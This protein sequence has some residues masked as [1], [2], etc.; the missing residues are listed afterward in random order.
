[1]KLP[2]VF[3]AGSR[4]AQAVV[5]LAVK[6]IA[7]SDGGH[8]AAEQPCAYTTANQQPLRTAGE[9]ST[10]SENLVALFYAREA[11]HHDKPA[12]EW[13][14]QPVCT[15]G[16][17]PLLVGRY[18][19]ALRELGVARGDRVMLK[20]E[21]SPAYVFTYLAILAAGAIFVPLNAAYTAAEVG[22]LVDDADPILLVHASDTP[23]PPVDAAGGPAHM[24]LEPDGSGSLTDLANRLD[25]DLSVEPVTARDLAAILFTSGTTGRPKG[26]ML[27]HGNLSS[28]VAA[29]HQTWQFSDAD[30][31][32]HTLPL[33]HAHGLFVA[34]HLGLYSAATL[35]MLPR[36][37]AA[38]VV[39]LLGEVSVFMGVPTFYTRLL[40]HPG[41]TREAVAAI[42]L[43]VSGSAPLLPSVFEAFEART[44]HRILER[45]GM[46]EAV[47]IT[48]NPY[49]Q[50]GRIPGTVGFPLPGVSLRIVGGA[51][52]AELPCGEVGE[53]EISGPNLC[54]GYWRRPEANAEAFHADGYFITGDTGF[55][56]DTGRVTIAGRSKDLIIS[57]GFNVYPAELEILLAE[58][59]GVT[60]IAVIGVPH[61]DF[62]EAV[63]AVVTADAGFVPASIN[64]LA[65]ERLARFKQPKAVFVLPE[66]PRNAMG[67]VLKAELR[68]RFG[69]TFTV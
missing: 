30:S 53:I 44:G 33:F 59:P 19:A 47:M 61:P 1:V 23:V 28:N 20:T 21:N 13:Q 58:V 40:D 49:D 62:G 60:D 45:Y 36:F 57:G 68:R 41:M 4:G 2:P 55:R 64:E 6:A 12:I 43:F 32:L 69:G 31:I 26:A 24:T 65:R 63:V 3:A 51:D 14:G 52:R 56:D 16:E 17:L 18:K 35:R 5:G 37:D 7:L 39:P 48:S 27:M 66:F 38:R 15:F 46:T 50:A 42:R 22:L 9:I 25:P 8:F 11:G 34:L 29:L 67:K 54:A 10:M